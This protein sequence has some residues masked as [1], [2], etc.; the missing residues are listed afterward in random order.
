MLIIQITSPIRVSKHL[1]V[2]PDYIS[3]QVVIMQ[4]MVLTHDPRHA[5]NYADVSMDKF[6]PLTYISFSI[7]LKFYVNR[8]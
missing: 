2:S 8:V 4:Y 7:A 5:L 6:S 3:L 1:L